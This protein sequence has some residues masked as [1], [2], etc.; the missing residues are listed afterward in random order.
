MRSLGDGLFGGRINS[1]SLSYIY[2]F[3]TN[4]INAYSMMH[5][6]LDSFIY[7]LYHSFKDNVR[8]CD[9]FSADI[10]NQTDYTPPIKKR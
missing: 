6:M 8:A 4:S 9:I 1:E 7:L 2:I 5:P 3:S 10:S